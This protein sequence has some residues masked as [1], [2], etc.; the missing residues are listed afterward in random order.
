M[1]AVIPF[2]PSDNNY[3]LVVPFDN[4]PTLIDTRWNAIDEAWYI[5]L[6]AED[7]SPIALNLKIVLGTNLARRSTHPFFYGQV[8]V[9]FDTSGKKKDAGYDD[10]GARVIVQ[11]FTIADITGQP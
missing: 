1:V 10:L 5:D 2:R 8:L 4:V 3:R 9:P 6:R 11:R 7:E